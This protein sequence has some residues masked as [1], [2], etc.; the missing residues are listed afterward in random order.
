MTEAESVVSAPVAVA[1]VLLQEVE[2][3]R[4]VARAVCPPAT[5]VVQVVQVPPGVVPDDWARARGVRTNV[6][7]AKATTSTISMARRR[8]MGRSIAYPLPCS[9]GKKKEPAGLHVF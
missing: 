3:I 1:V 5:F 8:F 6:P 4:E 9:L 7:A 2:V